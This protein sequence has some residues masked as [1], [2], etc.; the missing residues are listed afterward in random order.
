MAGTRN[1]VPRSDSEGSIGSTTKKWANCYFDNAHVGALATYAN[2]AAAI[3]G[4]LSQGD[5]Y[6]TSTGVVMCVYTP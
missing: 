4:G 2:N 5:F 1:L 3:V 6:I